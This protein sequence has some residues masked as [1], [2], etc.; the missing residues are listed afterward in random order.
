MRKYIA[1]RKTLIPHVYASV[2][3]KFVV[4]VHVC[5]KYIFTIRVYVYYVPL[6]VRLA[7]GERR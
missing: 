7:T 1:N 3:L 6:D 4:C 5:R 2:D